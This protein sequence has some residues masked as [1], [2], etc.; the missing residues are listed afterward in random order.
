MT[1]PWSLSFPFSYCLFLRFYLFL[2]RGKGGNI[3]WLPLAHPA[4]GIRLQPRH[5]SRTGNRTSDLLVCRPALNP[6]SHTSQDSHSFLYTFWIVSPLSKNNYEIYHFFHLWNLH[7]SN[8][9]PFKSLEKGEQRKWNSGRNWKKPTLFS[10]CIDLTFCSFV[11]DE[12]NLCNGKPVDGLTTLANGTLVA[13]RGELCTHLFFCPSFCSGR[14][15][16]PKP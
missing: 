10:F 3:H 12:T 11:L 8:Y 1:C 13:F 4:Q 15:W 6:R 2:E 9:I 16:E 5:V 7:T 14:S